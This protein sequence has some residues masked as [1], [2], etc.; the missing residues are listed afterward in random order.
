MEELME[1]S[2]RWGVVL[3][4]WVLA[5]G[6]SRACSKNFEQR[7][8]GKTT[9]SKYGVK[10]ERGKRG[11]HPR[12]P[13]IR[14]PLCTCRNFNY[15]RPGPPPTCSRSSSL[16]YVSI[17]QLSLVLVLLSQLACSPPNLLTAAGPTSEAKME[18]HTV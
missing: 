3:L 5:S 16:F 6:F 13:G 8:Q 4:F 1:G 12:R 14:C 15:R 9:T 18:E 2:P 11:A 7:I 17:I 10:R